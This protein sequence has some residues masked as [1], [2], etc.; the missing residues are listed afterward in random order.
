MESIKGKIVIITGASSGFGMAISRL[1]AENGAK[2][3]ISARREDKLKTLAKELKEKYNTEIL[4][5]KLDV[6]DNEAVKKAVASLP[7]E[8]KKIDILINN[9][10]LSRGLDKL[11]EGSIQDWEEMIDTNVKGLLY[12]SRAV[13]P[14][15][16]E[17]G[18]GHVVNIGSI[19]GHEVYPKGNVYCA[20]K[21]AVDAI[22]KGMRI[23]LNGTD[24]KVTTIDP[25]LA[26][27]EFSIVRFR[28]DSDK[29]KAVYTG[30]EALCAED[31]AD[32]A[33]Y[34]VTRRKNFVIAEMILLPVNQASAAV[35]NRK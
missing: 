15:M 5:I 8:W 20:S 12:V 1:F 22:T 33:L 6:R 32:A 30:I 19:A 4:T 34:A 17:R 16:V 18:S 13:I 26:E 11:H 14:G 9:A 35:V 25:G 2:L 21:H 10:G 31:I 28:G 24:V 3:I 29:A 27:T 7:D 23:D